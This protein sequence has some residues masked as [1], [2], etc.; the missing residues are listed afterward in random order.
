[1]CETRHYPNINVWLCLKKPV[2]M[3]NKD[4][5]IMKLAEDDKQ[6]I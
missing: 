5:N 3:Q 6:A 4:R 1:M 2:F